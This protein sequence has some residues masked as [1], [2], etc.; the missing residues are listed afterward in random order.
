MINDKLLRNANTLK[1]KIHLLS[2]LYF[3]N[4]LYLLSKCS[5]NFLWTFVIYNLLWIRLSLILGQ[6]IN[7]RLLI[8]YLN[9]LFQ[10]NTPCTVFKSI[11]Y[12][13]LSSFILEAFKICGKVHFYY[14]IFFI[15]KVYYLCHL[16]YC[17]NS[18][19]FL[20]NKYE[21]SKNIKK[22]KNK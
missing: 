21:L 11:W 19:Y 20:I 13:D 5:I 8:L 14:Y 4:M 3:G 1:K 17:G 2:Q 7:M 15:W 22:K 18:T 12:I 9:S 6:K 16:L 10:T